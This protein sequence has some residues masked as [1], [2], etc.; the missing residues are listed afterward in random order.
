MTTL[1]KFMWPIP[2]RGLAR[3]LPRIG[4]PSLVVYG[5][6]DK[7]VPPDYAEDFVAGLPNASS[8]LVSDAGHMVPIESPDELLALIN[9]FL[10]APSA[11]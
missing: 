3:R 7:F 10:G 11:V 4:A 8:R 6:Q 1:A 9:E 2:E 5:A